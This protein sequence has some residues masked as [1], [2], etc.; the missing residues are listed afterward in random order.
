[1]GESGLLTRRF[2]RYFQRGGG[3][4]PLLPIGW[5]LRPTYGRGSDVTPLLLC[6]LLTLGKF[7]AMS[8]G[9]LLQPGM[10]GRHRMQQA[11]WSEDGQCLDG[12]QLHQQFHGGRNIK[13]G[14][15][16]N[17]YMKVTFQKLTLGPSLPG[18]PAG[19]LGPGSP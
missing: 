12:I 10:T 16:C 3:G 7:L 11:R 5:P 15:C 6:C 4:M 8:L 14:M 18:T 1:M 9:L 2:A 17:K 13:T 19:P